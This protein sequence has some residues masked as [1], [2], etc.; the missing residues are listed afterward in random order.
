[1]KMNKF[2]VLIY[3]LPFYLIP[4]LIILSAH[5]SQNVNNKSTT[6]KTVEEN[7]ARCLLYYTT[8]KHSRRYEIVYKTEWYSHKYI[9]LSF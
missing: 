8:E 2:L 3:I 6:M 4:T 1:M 7:L 5:Q 9:I